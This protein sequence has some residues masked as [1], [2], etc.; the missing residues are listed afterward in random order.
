MQ[1]YCGAQHVRLLMPLPQHTSARKYTNMEKSEQI[2]NVWKWIKRKP[3]RIKSIE[4]HSSF[5]SVEKLQSFRQTSPWLNWFWWDYSFGEFHKYSCRDLWNSQNVSMKFLEN[6]NFTRQNTSHDMEQ[7]FLQSR[8]KIIN[9]NV[10][11]HFLQTEHWLDSSGMASMIARK[12]KASYF[13]QFQFFHWIHRLD[14]GKLFS[15]NLKE[16]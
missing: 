2:E 9:S 7:D 16:D 12:T 5:F 8:K 13:V 15:I 1:T 6:I 4:F 11:N 10:S 3:H 14:L